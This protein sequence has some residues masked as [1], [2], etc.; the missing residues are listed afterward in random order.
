MLPWKA[1]FLSSRATSLKQ[2]LPSKTQ[3]I[4]IPI[5]WPRPGSSEL[6]IKVSSLVVCYKW[7]A[8][9]PAKT[10]APEHLVAVWG[11]VGYRLHYFQWDNRKSRRY[12]VTWDSWKKM[13]DEGLA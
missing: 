3:H 13:Y 8:V 1:S 2:S 12:C 6:E 9:L 11:D 5:K 7:V 10:P 4:H